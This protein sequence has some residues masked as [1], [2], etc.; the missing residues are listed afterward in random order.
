VSALE[1]RT[2]SADMVHL[3]HFSGMRLKRPRCGTS[4]DLTT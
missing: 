3:D 2:S 1:V 4:T